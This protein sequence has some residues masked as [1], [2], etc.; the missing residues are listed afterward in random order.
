MK[1]VL[2]F[3]IHFFIFF[4]NDSFDKSYHTRMKKYS[5]LALGDSYT[6]G[7]SVPAAENFPNQTAQLLR[8][9]GFD[10]EAPEI[11][12][13]T[14]WTTDEL[15]NAILKHKL[16]ATF[17]VV[18]LL[19]G[20]NNQ[21]RERAVE[22]YKPEFELLLQ[23]AIHFAG[24]NPHHVIVLSIPDWGVTPFAVDRNRN[25]IA[26]EIDAFN[27]VNKS[28]SEKYEVHY[29]D[30]TPGTR[31]AAHDRSLIATDGLHPSG[32]EYSL[33]ATELEK[34]IATLLK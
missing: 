11:I 28:I 23:Q 3:A 21:Y 14:G 20:V 1:F 18:T 34:V 7:E 22:N 10:F 12:A 9:A 31:E 27:A 30:I 13:T 5:Y 4:N 29:L 24:N 15:Q 33:W 25:R 19:I 16:Q 32:K 26:K 17:D 2:F 6:I 8:N